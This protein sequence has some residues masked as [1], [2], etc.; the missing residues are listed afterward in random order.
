MD[1]ILKQ[2]ALVSQKKFKLVKQSSDVNLKMIM[3]KLEDDK[4]NKIKKNFLF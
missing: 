3:D 4:N 1:N 2:N